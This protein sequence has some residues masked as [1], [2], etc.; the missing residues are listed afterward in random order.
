MELT[1][2]EN[3]ERKREASLQPLSASS[4]LSVPLSA[5][6]VPLSALSVPLSALSVPDT[7]SAISPVSRERGAQL[8]AEPI[9]RRTHSRRT[10]VHIAQ[11][12]ASAGRAR[13]E[14]DRV[15]ACACMSVLACVCV[16]V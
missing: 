6:S 10:H 14:A 8:R 2:R 16:R 15:R 9:S 13:F 1:M 3:E 7:K 4:A 12:I 11:V 5:L